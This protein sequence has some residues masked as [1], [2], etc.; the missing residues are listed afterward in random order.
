MGF[1][2]G[3]KG[4]I[5]QTIHIP[6]LTQLYITVLLFYY[7]LLVSALIDHHQANIYKKNLQML[8]TDWLALL[9]HLVCMKPNFQGLLWDEFGGLGEDELKNYFC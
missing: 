8:I 1:N 3:F 5:K 7:W 6:R 4:L 9:A 2:S